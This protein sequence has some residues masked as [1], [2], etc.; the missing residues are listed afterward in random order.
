MD[1]TIDEKKDHII[2]YTHRPYKLL[3]FDTKGNYL[4]EERMSD[5]YRSVTLSGRDLLFVNAEVKKG[6]MIYSKNLDT[7]EERYIMPMLNHSG[8]YEYFA[9]GNPSMLKGMN[10]NISFPYVDTLYEAKDGII[11]AKYHIDF[12]KKK[13]PDYVYKRRTPTSDIVKLAID[14]DYGFGIAN[15]VELKD[16][17]YFTYA[18][19]ISVFYSKKDKKVVSFRRMI[20]KDN[21]LEVRNIFAHDGNDS[22]FTSLYSASSFLNFMEILKIRNKFDRLPA[23]IKQ[24]ASATSENSNPIIFVCTLKGK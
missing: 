8:V 22:V 2:L 21:S 11:K 9:W 5:L 18:S 15:F 17:V 4:E 16:M 7:H 24:M 19:G 13:L 3:Y 10:T 6:Y 12:G 23:D 20:N 14:K 1:F